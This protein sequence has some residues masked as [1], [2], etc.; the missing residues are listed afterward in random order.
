[1]QHPESV[2]PGVFGSVVRLGRGSSGAGCAYQLKR[3]DKLTEIASLVIVGSFGATG[4]DAGNGARR[5]SQ[6]SSCSFLALHHRFV[7]CSDDKCS[8]GLVVDGANRVML[9]P[10]ATGVSTDSR[11]ATECVIAIYID[12]IDGTRR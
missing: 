6:M 1:M 9:S 8:S 2:R 3:V 12:Q 7:T 4:I 10:P 11:V 5:G